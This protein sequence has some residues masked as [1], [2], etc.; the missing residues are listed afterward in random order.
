MVLLGEMQIK[1]C[2]LDICIL[3]EFEM[4]MIGDLSFFL[5]LQIKQLS[6]GIFISQSKYTLNMLKKFGLD[7]SK[8]ARTP[9]GTTSKLTRDM[10]GK[11]VDPT[12]FHSMIG[13][14]LY[15]T[16]SRPAICFSVGLC[17][18]YQSTPTESHLTAVKR[19]MKYVVGT[20]EFGLW[21]TND[22]NM[23]LVGYSDSDWAGNL[24]DR[25]STSGGCFYL[26]NNLV[27][28]HS[29]KQNSISLSTAEAEYIAAGSCCTQ[30]LWMNKML[31]NYGYP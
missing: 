6:T 12:L 4:S 19:I 20:V 22:S 9:I 15:L 1:L 23:S 25:K 7:H 2:L 13:S 17:A 27:S 30:L 5:G 11:L 14:L 18:R 8:H 28:W 16:A 21:Y 3:S 24:D 10:L 26:G 29:K 31:A